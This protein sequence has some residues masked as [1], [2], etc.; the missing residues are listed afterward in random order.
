MYRTASQMSLAERLLRFSL[1]YILLALMIMLSIVDLPVP[2]HMVLRPFWFLIAVFYWMLYRP[3][4]LPL[5]ALFLCGLLLDTLLAAPLGLHAFLLVLAGWTVR[6]QRR[7]LFAQSFP[8]L[9]VAF[10]LLVIMSEALFA[11]VS[12]VIRPGDIPASGFLMPYV[13]QGLSTIL[14]YPVMVL[15]F[16]WPHKLLPSQKSLSR[17]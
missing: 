13:W 9:L 11:G 10:T 2:H 5:W 3:T 14:L 16:Y 6:R 12:W 7:F 17:L 8:V 1:V 4:L 15:V